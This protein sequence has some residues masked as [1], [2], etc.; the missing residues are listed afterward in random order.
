M[1]SPNHIWIPW[2][3]LSKGRLMVMKVTVTIPAGRQSLQTQPM[4]SFG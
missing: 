4:Q 3:I 2:I 1:G